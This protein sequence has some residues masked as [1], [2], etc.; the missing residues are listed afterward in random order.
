[1]YVLRTL[2]GTSKCRDFAKSII[3]RRFQSTMVTVSAAETAHGRFTL[4]LC[5][6]LVS[7]SADGAKKLASYV[8]T[9]AISVTTRNK[10][11]R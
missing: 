7:L 8:A 4:K 10:I 6:P 5:V 3:A 11:T 1:M 2:K 9:M